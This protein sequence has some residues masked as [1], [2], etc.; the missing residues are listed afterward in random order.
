MKEP[1]IF[2]YATGEL[3]QD[4]FIAWLLEW[5]NP[6]YNGKALHSCS[7]ELIKEFGF[8]G[9]IKSVKLVL[10]QK[11]IDVLCIINEGLDEYDKC[12]LLIED[13]TNTSE[14]GNQL[15]TYLE[16]VTKAYKDHIVLPIYFKTGFQLNYREVDNEGYKRFLRDDFLVILENHVDTIKNNIFLDYY[17]NLLQ[18]QEEANFSSKLISEWN[19]DSWKSNANRWNGFFVKLHEELNKDNIVSGNLSGYGS[20]LGY[21]WNWQQV[22]DTNIHIYCRINIKTMEFAI[23]LESPKEKISIE[24]SNKIVNRIDISKEFRFNKGKISN[25]KIVTIKK[26][27]ESFL[28]ENELGYIEFDKTVEKLK[29]L[30]DFVT[31]IS[32]LEI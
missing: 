27:D 32:K 28:I 26:L 1:N 7:K 2:K 12:V 8:L 13:K 25:S 30:S 10:Q 14:H 9:E 20:S 4:A 24:L 16:N 21:W 18:I 23:K 17:R 6:C 19:S 11:K 22:R 5:A 29:S 31:E 15:A 3:S